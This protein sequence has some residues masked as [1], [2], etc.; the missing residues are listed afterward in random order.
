MD[1]LKTTLQ[2]LFDATKE[3]NTTER[4][5]RSILLAVNSIKSLVY[6]YP[7]Y[8]EYD[9]G[10]IEKS[11]VLSVTNADRVFDDYSYAIR[12]EYG[13]EVCYILNEYFYSDEDGNVLVGL[14]EASREYGGAE[15]GGWYYTNWYHKETKEMPFDEA[16]KYIE[17]VS[18]ENENVCLHQ[19]KL[20]ARLELYEG[21]YEKVGREYYS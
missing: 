17:Q 19:G 7:K 16:I 11:F 2:K 20:D 14:Y 10:K 13:E 4:E 3:L 21:Q 5:L 12:N 15:E 9:N 1:K 18:N 6:Q 8:D